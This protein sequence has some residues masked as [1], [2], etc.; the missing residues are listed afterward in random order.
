MISHIT[1]HVVDG[2]AL[3]P[4]QYKNKPRMV[5]WLTAY[6]QRVQEVEDALWDVFFDRVLTNGP[7]GD[8]LAKIGKIVGQASLG[9]SDAIFLLYIEA[10]ILTNKS[11]GKRE[12]LIAIAS[13]L[14]PSTT[15]YV[16]D[17]QPAAVLIEPLGPLPSGIDPYVVARD[18]LGRAK[19]AGIG[20][21]FVWTLAPQANTIIGGSVHSPG[22]SAGPPAT[23]TGVGAGQVPG[24]VHHGGF[25]AGPVVV[26]DGGGELAG[27]I[28][29]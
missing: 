7:T 13:T 26:G 12:E 18:F 27:V 25:S 15:I 5:A 6:L 19:A 21:S 16:K 9:A 2:I 17:F 24:S 11:T 8:L 4:A 28:E 1:T 29:A 10:R 22:F 20:L 14:V 23:N 3:L